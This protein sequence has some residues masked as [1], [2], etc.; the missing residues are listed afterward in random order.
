MFGGSAG[1]IA[2]A[3]APLSEEEKKRRRNNPTPEEVAQ[4]VAAEKSYLSTLRFL[5]NKRG[6]GNSRTWGALG[7]TEIEA[8]KRL[9]AKYPTVLG[10]IGSLFRG[11]IRKTKGKGKNKRRQ[12]RRN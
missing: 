2:R 8:Y 3:Y 9:N 7:P 11:G 5:K 6:L 10:R 1:T 12:T 4:D